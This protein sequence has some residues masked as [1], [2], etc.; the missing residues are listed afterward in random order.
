MRLVAALALGLA[1][2]AVAGGA[3]ARD[4]PGPTARDAFLPAFAR[5]Y[6]PGRSGQI[7]I[8]PKEGHFVTQPADAFMHGSPWAYD[9]RVPLILHGPRHVVR[10]RY[11]TPARHQDIAPTVLALLGRAPAPTMTGAPLLAALRPDAAPPR[12]VLLVVLDAFRADYMERL[13][14]PTLSRLAREGAAFGHA[15]VDYLPTATGVAHATISTG[16]DPAVHGIVVNNLFDA[17]SG[18]VVDAFADGTSNNLMAP[19]LADVWMDATGGK[20]IVAAQAGY[21]YA[22]GALAGHGACRPG[23]HPVLA[24]AYDRKTGRWETGS[25]EC[26]RVPPALAGRT[27]QALWEGAGGRWRGHDV[28]NPDEIRKSAL[29]AGYEADALISVLESEPIGADG[30]TDLLLVNF[31]TPDFVSHRYGPDAPETADAAVAT[32]AALGRLVE[33]LEAKTQGDAVVVVTADHG[34]PRLADPSRRHLAADVVALLNARFDPQ[35]RRVVRNYEP[36]N[37]QLYVDEARLAELGV[38]LADVARH[39]E[40]LPFV[41]AAYTADEVRRAVRR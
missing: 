26:F 23:G 33:A 32:D 34:M 8:V 7:M 14:L 16:A 37:A 6:Y 4:G 25:K 5:S 41:F 9:A 2:L 28:G 13:S 10:G 36:S 40:S 11:D 18:K 29:F 12:A 3:T 21:F 27:P 38:P 15:R 31:K 24:A 19:A 17:A 35:G 39:L 22:A 20:A 1:A 30:V